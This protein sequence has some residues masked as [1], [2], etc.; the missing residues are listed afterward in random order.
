MPIPYVRVNSPTGWVNAPSTATP[1]SAANLN[2]M[3]QGIVDLDSTLNASTGSDGASLP[4][5][6]GPFTFANWL[7]YILTLIKNIT[8]K[9]HWYTAPVTSIES[10]N[11]TMGT[12]ANLSGATFTGTVNVSS[13]SLQQGGKNALYANAGLTGKI[14]AQSSAP[15][16]PADGDL[17]IDTSTVL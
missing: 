15:S 11:T 2:I 1:Q 3:D 13:G 10:L 14:S 7:N 16:S 12:K 4:A 6:N 9:A 5:T 8:G 17:W